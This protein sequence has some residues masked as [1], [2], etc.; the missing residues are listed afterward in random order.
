MAS[1]HVNR[2]N[3]PNTWLHRQPANVKKSL[4]NSEPSTHGT[5]RTLGNVSRL[6]AFGG[7]A[8]IAPKCRLSAYDKADIPRTLLLCPLSVRSGRGWA[9]IYPPGSCMSQTGQRGD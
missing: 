9:W 5:K 7:K 2:T 8:D 6:S 3:R 4:A 1:G